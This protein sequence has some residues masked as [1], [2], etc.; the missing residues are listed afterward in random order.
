MSFCIRGQGEVI[1]VPGTD[2]EQALC[3]DCEKP[4][5]WESRVAD[6]CGYRYTFWTST[7]GCHRVPLKAALAPSDG[8][9][10]G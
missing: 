9:S 8:E 10:H 6:C 5:R 3:G 1:D 7:V 4:L 2:I